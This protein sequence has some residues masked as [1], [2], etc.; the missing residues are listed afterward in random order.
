MLNPVGWA[1]GPAKRG[2]ASPKRC[3]MFANGPEHLETLGYL[4]GVGAV[5]LGAFGLLA[6]AAPRGWAW[7][8]LPLLALAAAG[9]PLLVFTGLR[10]LPTFTLAWAALA[11]VCAACYL[12]RS[13]PGSRFI[14]AIAAFLRRPATPWAA[15]AALGF[16]A[17]AAAGLLPEDEA[18]ARLARMFGP[19]VVDDST[20]Q[21]VDTLHAVTDRGR[22]VQLY[23]P[24]LA[25][26]TPAE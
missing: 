7:R 2:C 20:L 15:V 26:M 24:E 16:V 17:F 19:Q 4:L 25:A 1:N 18:T 9:V 22:P 3:T 6:E 8:L 13:S 14:A 11:M 21:P 10:T 12:V 23:V 5:L